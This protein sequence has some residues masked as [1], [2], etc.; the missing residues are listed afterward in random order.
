MENQVDLELAASKICSPEWPYNFCIRIEVDFNENTKMYKMVRSNRILKTGTNK[1]TINE[2][3]EAIRSRL[4]R[5]AKKSDISEP[6]IT[7]KWC[8]ENPYRMRFN[9]NG[10][11]QR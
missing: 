6:K 4:I 5:L 11:L 1:E 9:L 2:A 3:V 8:D 10:K 7:F